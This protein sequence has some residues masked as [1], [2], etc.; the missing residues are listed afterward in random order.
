M[1]RELECYEPGD[2]SVSVEGK[3]EEDY[4]FG[5]TEGPD[6][7]DDGQGRFIKGEKSVVEVG[8]GRTRR[9]HQANGELEKQLGIC[10]NRIT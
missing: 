7:A 10:P 2:L 8:N 3:G 1:A 5:I 4:R 6:E 9:L